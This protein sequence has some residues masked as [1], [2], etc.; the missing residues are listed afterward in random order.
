MLYF[1]SKH[2]VVSWD[3][4]LQ[5]VLVEWKGFAYGEEFKSIL[6]QGAE[7]LKQMG[8]S[9]VLMDTR[10]G[11]AIK[12]EDKTWI[13]E[14]FVRRAYESGLRRLAMLEP[15]SMVAKLSVTRTVSGLGSL[16]YLQ[17]NFTDWD[18]AVEWLSVTP[19]PALAIS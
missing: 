3:E 10:Q 7:L 12:A 18:E 5:S 6:L 17:E 8:G 16:P 14:F 9:R 15:A 19:K 1:E 11:S 13:G 4:N 2:G